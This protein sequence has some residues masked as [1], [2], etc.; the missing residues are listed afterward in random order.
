MNSAAVPARIGI[1]R[2][3][4]SGPASA[5]S[6]AHNERH[7]AQDP[8]THRL[9]AV[10]PFA[11]C[12]PA[13]EIGDLIVDR[14]VR[15][16][17]AE[18]ELALFFFDL[19]LRRTRLGRQ[20]GSANCSVVW[21]VRGATSLLG[22]GVFSARGS[23]GSGTSESDRMRSRVAMRGGR[24]RPLRACGNR[25]APGAELGVGNGLLCGESSGAAKSR[26][27]VLRAWKC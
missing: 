21:P 22:V 24:I 20:R 2:S 4:P 16:V 7:P 3:N 1:T 25:L 12:G 10:A 8:E 5:A 9:E 15:R 6:A 14:V 11:G 23:G 13:L 18:Y 27:A 26:A 17:L 19:D